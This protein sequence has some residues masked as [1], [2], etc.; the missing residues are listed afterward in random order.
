MTAQTQSKPR[1]EARTPSPVFELGF[2]GDRHLLELVDGF[3]GIATA[4]VE[5]GTNVG[6]TAAYV[7][8][9]YPSLPVFSCEPDSVAFAVASDT[10]KPYPNARLAATP[11]PAF[12]ETLFAEQPDLADGLGFFF[13]DAH[14]YGFDWPLRDEVRLLT[15][16]LNKGLLLIDDF[17][18]PSR[19][20]FRH[21][22]YD[23]QDCGFAYIQQALA[24]GR[25]YTLMY[26][27][28]RERT[29]QH[30]PLVG[31]VLIA[32]GVEATRIP[33]LAGDRWECRTW[34]G[35]GPADECPPC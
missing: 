20:W 30:H 9:T 1:P 24:R 28:Y 7:A 29:S 17:E 33:P 14:G 4:F 23:N 19:P 3:L 32:F 34:P 22:A 27:A 13:L 10:L 26:P 5:T 21:C 25:D 12:L 35:R 6:S 11:S 16:R 8:R 31:F 2:H 18:V 15:H